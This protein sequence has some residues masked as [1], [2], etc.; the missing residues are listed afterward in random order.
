M[1]LAWVSYAVDTY[2]EYRRA[3]EFQEPAYTCTSLDWSIAPHANARTGL[4]IGVVMGAN[5]RSSRIPA[6]AIGHWQWRD[7]S[8]RKSGKV[9]QSN[10]YNWHWVQTPLLDKL[11]AQRQR[12][13]QLRSGSTQREPAHFI[14]WQ[15]LK[16]FV[17]IS[18]CQNEAFDDIKSLSHNRCHGKTGLIFI[19]L[20]RQQHFLFISH[21]HKDHGQRRFNLDS[22]QYSLYLYSAST[23]FMFF[24]SKL[25][26]SFPYFSLPRML[27][28]INYQLYWILSIQKDART[29][30][31]LWYHIATGQKS[32]FFSRWPFFV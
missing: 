13:D 28:Y 32:I 14:P 26:L 4:T 25:V 5:P 31:P 27:R 7:A 3:Y 18:S 17:P 24:P 23:L 12:S 11:A 2:I 15:P 16:I 8:E 30:L 20:S 19:F 21:F 9:E 6:N 10:R 29:I 1:K 22:W